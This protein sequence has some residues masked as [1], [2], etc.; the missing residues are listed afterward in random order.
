[1]ALK[2]IGERTVGT[3]NGMKSGFVKD[4]LYR[5]YDAGILVPG[6]VAV[7]HGDFVSWDGTKWVREADIKIARSDEI[8]NTNSSIAP[9]Y[10][11]TTYKANS[12]VMH[13]GILYTNPN[14][15]GT[16]E[17]WNPAHW[18]QTTV[19]EMMANAGGGYKEV[20]LPPIVSAPY[21]IPVGNREIVTVSYIGASDTDEIQLQLADDCTDAIV[22]FANKRPASI[23]FNKLKIM[24]QDFNDIPL[25]GKTYLIDIENETEF[26]YSALFS[27]LGGGSVYD[28]PSDWSEVQVGDC[29]TEVDMDTIYATE[30]TDTG[31]LIEIKGNIAI[32]HIH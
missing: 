16:A 2:F 8:T 17:D 1:M 30:S 5:V 7:D 27:T 14:A 22:F 31:F 3:L 25:F 21:N 9:D 12:Y 32:L 26:A 29:V 18:A 19:A 20:T 24:R 11:K 10:T 15:I 23:A 6:G 13:G 28:I 4:D